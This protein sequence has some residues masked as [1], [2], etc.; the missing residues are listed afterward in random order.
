MVRWLSS[1]YI[2]HFLYLFGTCA[3]SIVFYG[4]LSHLISSFEFSIL[5]NFQNMNPFK[6]LDSWAFFL[7]N[8]IEKRCDSQFLYRITS[9]FFR[10]KRERSAAKLLSGPESLRKIVCWIFNYVLRIWVCKRNFL[11]C[12]NT[13]ITLEAIGP[14]TIK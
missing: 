9:F 12:I 13:I 10:F 2:A 8:W 6:W 5:F 1:T 11:F 3:T 14:S 4:T 7:S